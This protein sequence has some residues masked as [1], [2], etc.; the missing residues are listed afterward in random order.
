MVAVAAAAVVF[1]KRRRV[2]FEFLIALP[3]YVC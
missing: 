3:P 2:T 1:K